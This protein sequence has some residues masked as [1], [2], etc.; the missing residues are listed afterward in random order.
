M[1]FSEPAN[2]SI[3]FVVAYG[4]IPILIAW[5]AIHVHRSNARH[6]FAKRCGISAGVLGAVLAVAILN[7]IDIS[8]Y[9]ETDFMFGVVF[10][11]W[12]A[13]LGVLIGAAIDRFRFGRADA[14][15]TQA[16]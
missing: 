4:T 16:S 5:C 12:F 6:L 7:A 15:E 13:A 2:I 10:A 14:K 9:P 3:A 1:M 8:K 11:L